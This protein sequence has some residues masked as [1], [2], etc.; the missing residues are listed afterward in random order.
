M[1]IQLQR[2]RAVSIEFDIREDDGTF[3]TLSA[4][5]QL[6]F[7]VKKNESQ[8]TYSIYK[9]LTSEDLNPEGNAYVLQLTSEDTNIMPGYYYYDFSLQSN[10]NLYPIVEYEPFVIT[11]SVLEI[12]V[13]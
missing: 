1:K 5:E 12:E 10:G 2:A 8:S 13:N 7:A 9:E 11:K 4:G 3:L 6:I